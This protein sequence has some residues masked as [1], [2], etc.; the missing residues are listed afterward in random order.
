MKVAV[1]GPGAVGAV[2]AAALH[3]AGREVALYGRTA[4]EHIEVRRDDDAPIVV[5]GPVITDL[6]APRE[7]VDVVIFAVKSTQ[8]EAAGPWLTGLCGPDTVVCVLQNGVEQVEL[9]SPFA[10]GAQ[11]IPSVIW[12]AAEPQPDGSVWLRAD[13]RL[14]VPAGS[15]GQVVADALAGTLCTV[16]LSDDFTTE[17][18]HKLMLNAVAGLMAL[19]GRR[20]LMFGH[21]AAA[22]LA[23]AYLRECL[24]VARAEGA[25]LSDELPAQVVE[26][27]GRRDMGT[28][29]L[30][31]RIAGRPMEWQI[32]NGV[33]LRRAAAHGLAAPI[34]DILVALLAVASDGPG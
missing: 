13:Q 25:V 31:D 21:P 16:E 27:F 7:P 6:G 15:A 1:V 29:I 22:R 19:T 8:I 9:V 11:V 10:V 30:I 26:A 4:R 17:T 24:A 34:S 18:W 20:S 12:F 28:S 32:R 14:T 23:E 2:I 5:P 3:D 33:I